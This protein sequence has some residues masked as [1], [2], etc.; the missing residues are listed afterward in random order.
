MTI[1]K[2]NYVSV[3]FSNLDHLF[4]KAC[5]IYW[6]TFFSVIQ[7]LFLQ[8]FILQNNTNKILFRLSSLRDAPI[9][10]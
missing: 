4:I 9:G 10:Y 1:W 8:Q 5:I 6:K 2:T 7:I 3:Y